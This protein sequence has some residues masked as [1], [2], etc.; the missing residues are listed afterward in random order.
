M[1]RLLP[2]LPLALLAAGCT[3]GEATDSGNVTA[4]QQAAA[5]MP[6]TAADLPKDMPPAARKSAEGAMKAN[7]AMGAQQNA[8]MEAMK[9][10]T[11]GGAH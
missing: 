4:A 11:Q 7:T 8:Q 3:G 6:K 9:K 5:A 1:R 10:A 2:L